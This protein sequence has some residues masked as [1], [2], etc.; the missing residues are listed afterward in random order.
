MITLLLVVLSLLFDV[1]SQVTELGLAH[2]APIIPEARFRK[3]D[4]VDL[5]RY[6]MSTL[7]MI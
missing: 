3:D 5:M 7:K 6:H 4:D 2:S 1:V